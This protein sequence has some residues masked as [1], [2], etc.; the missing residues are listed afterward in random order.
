MKTLITLL[1]ALIIG[2]GYSFVNSPASYQ[3]GSPTQFQADEPLPGND[4]EDDS[5]RSFMCRLFNVFCP[6]SKSD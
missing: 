3:P 4:G 5:E 6:E 1:V 2:A